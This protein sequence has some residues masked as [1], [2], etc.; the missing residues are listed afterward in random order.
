MLLDDQCDELDQLKAEPVAFETL[1]FSSSNQGVFM[2]YVAGFCVSSCGE[3]VWACHIEKKVDDDYQCRLMMH[4]FE[5]NSNFFFEYEHADLILAVSVSEAFHMA[6]SGGYDKT[7]VLHGLSSRKMIQKFD[8]KYGDLLCLFNLGS[9]V[10]VGDEHTVRFLDLET[11]QIDDSEVKTGAKRINCMNRSIKENEESDQMVL[12]VG[13]GN[14]NKIDKITIPKTIARPTETTNSPKVTLEEIEMLRDQL[15]SF[16]NENSTLKKENENLRSKLKQKETENALTVADI[17]KKISKK[18]KKLETQKNLNSQLQ[19]ELDQ[20][21][22]KL[23]FTE[24]Q[25]QSLETVNESNQQKINDL[26]SRIKQLNSKI[27]TIHN[28]KDKVTEK[29]SH[30]DQMMVFYKRACENILFIIKMLIDEKVS[31]DKVLP[32]VYSLPGDLLRESGIRSE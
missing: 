5:A 3:K 6:M 20:L 27:L 2:F 11:R 1:P 4:D 29:Y 31:M 7:L 28:E 17:E 8:M 16:K 30:A 15:E 14:S 12:L 21:K 13:G 24:T 26:T 10:A 32:L 18:S 19:K 23:T 25:A 22:D 9:A